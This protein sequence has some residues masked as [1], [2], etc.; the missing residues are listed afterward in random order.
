M[1]TPECTT[2]D[3]FF[4][5][6]SC[7][8]NGWFVKIYTDVHFCVPL[9]FIH[10]IKGSFHKSIIITIAIS[11]EIL[12]PMAWLIMLQNEGLLTVQI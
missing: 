12:P 3:S 9:S 2:L 4:I 6:F 7:R 5:A 1:C 8:Q 10:I 11:L